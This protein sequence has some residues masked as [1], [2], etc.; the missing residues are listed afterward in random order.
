MAINNNAKVCSNV[1]YKAEQ[2]FK[3][4]VIEDKF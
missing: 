3:R 4:T 2:A 1:E